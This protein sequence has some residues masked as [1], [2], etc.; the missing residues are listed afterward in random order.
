MDYPSENTPIPGVAQVFHVEHTLGVIR[1]RRR[2]A[3]EERTKTQ[4]LILRAPWLRAVDP[5]RLRGRRG[6]A[7]CIR[8]NRCRLSSCSVS[9]LN[10]ARPRFPATRSVVASADTRHF[11]STS[12]WHVA[13]LDFGARHSALGTRHLAHG[14]WHLQVSNLVRPASTFARYARTGTA[15]HHRRP[16]NLEARTPHV[17]PSSHI[18]RRT[19]LARVILVVQRR[20]IGVF[21]TTTRR[22][23]S[24]SMSG[25]VASHASGGRRDSARSAPPGPLNRNSCPPGRKNA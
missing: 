7:S 18:A 17:R 16:S 5:A 9:G 1:A 4:A 22:D 12:R 2:H 14:S 8:W 13:R 3:N 11:V 10:H 6:Q 21:V 23:R 15:A 19:H 24:S 25:Y 20:P